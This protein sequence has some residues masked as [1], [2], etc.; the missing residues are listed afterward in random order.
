M[1]QLISELIREIDAN[2]SYHDDVLN[3]SG[4]ESEFIKLRAIYKLGY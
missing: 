4:R 3:K 2:Y 1:I